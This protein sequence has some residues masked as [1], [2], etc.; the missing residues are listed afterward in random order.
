MPEYVLG[1]YVPECVLGAYV[2]ECVLGAYVPEYVLGAYVPEYV[3][4]A[5]V[6]E[7]VLGAYVPE[8]V[9]GAY[10]PECVLGAYVPKC[11]LGAYVPEY[12]LGAYVPEYVLGAYVPE[13]VLGAYVPE[14]VLSAYVPEYVLGAYVP[15]H[16]LGAYVHECVLRVYMNIMD[17]SLLSGNFL[18]A[19]S[20]AACDFRPHIP[21]LWS[22]VCTLDPVPP[23]SCKN[24]LVCFVN[25]AMECIVS[26]TIAGK[27]QRMDLRIISTWF[28]WLY[29]SLCSANMLSCLISN[30]DHDYLSCVHCVFMYIVSAVYAVECLNTI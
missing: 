7:Y 6:P 17:A 28:N 15:E 9:L 18:E 11:V 24:W 23:T 4:G 3:L 8:C 30:A 26:S 14:C 2:P 19:T 22:A 25:K 12:V 16:V 21:D 5:Y 10:V 20:T 27:A 29:W 1:A 13:C